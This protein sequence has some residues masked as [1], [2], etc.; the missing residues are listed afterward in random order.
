MQIARCCKI[1]LKNQFQPSNVQVI[2]ILKQGQYYN[3]ILII[4]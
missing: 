4:K 3:N 2:D 1:T